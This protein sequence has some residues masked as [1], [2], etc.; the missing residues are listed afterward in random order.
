MLLHDPHQGPVEPEVRRPVPPLRRGQGRPAHRRQQRQLRSPGG[1]HDHRGTAQHAVRRFADPP[2]PGLCGH[3]RGALPLRPLPGCRL[4]RGDHPPPRVG[5]PG[6]TVGHRVERGGVR[7]LAR[8]RPRRHRGDRL[9]APA[10][11]AV[12]A[13]ARRT[14]DVRPLRGGRGATRRP[15]TPTSPA[16]PAWRPSAPR[17]R[18]A[19]AAVRCA[20]PTASASG[21]SAPGCGPRDAPRSSSGWTTRACCPPSRSSSAAPPARPPYSSVCTPGCGST[22]TRRGRRCAP[23]SRSA[24]RPSRPRTF[25][26]SGTTSGWKAWS[27]VSPPITQACCRRSRR[28]WRSCS[29]AGS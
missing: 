15:S 20:R 5:D 10:R 3:G 17:T 19:D 12:P 11:A 8:H 9:R 7:R 28:S 4:G 25:M 16:S 14:P 29:C 22:T 24:P 6:L 18:T 13:R 23:S 1:R 21:D 2:R 26:S 27:A